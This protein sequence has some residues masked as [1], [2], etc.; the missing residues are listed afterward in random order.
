MAIVRMSIHN[1]AQECRYIN[2]FQGKKS[3]IHIPGLFLFSPMVDMKLHGHPP[4]AIFADMGE[5]SLFKRLK[6]IKGDVPPPKKLKD[7]FRKLFPDAVLTDIFV[8][9]MDGDVIAQER[10]KSMGDWEIVLY[11]KCFEKDKTISAQSSFI[12]EV[13]HACKEPLRAILENRYTEAAALLSSHHLM[14]HFL[15]EDVLSALSSAHS[16]EQIEPLQISVGLEIRLSLVALVDVSLEAK[17]GGT[18]FSHF[19]CLL[20][21]AREIPM[22]RKYIPNPTSQF[23]AWLKEKVDAPAIEKLFGDNL[24][25]EDSASIATL[26]RWSA[27]THQPNENAIKKV[28]VQLFEDEEYEPLWNMY[29]ASVYLNFIG[30]YAKLYQDRAIMFAATQQPVAVAPWPKLPFGYDS[31]D[32]WLEA[33]YPIWLDFHRGRITVKETGKAA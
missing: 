3:P 4:R 14:Q 10:L 25:D 27:G 5:E 22:S 24:L 18:N 2:P 17:G 28:A 33:R 32:S 30:Y 11:D 1:V 15:S 12:L 29:W 23:Y 9:A 20:P 21:Y 7:D 13:E 8:A 31:V 6:E 19:R 26:K 16:S